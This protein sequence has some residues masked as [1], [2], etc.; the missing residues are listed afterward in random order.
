MKDYSQ[1][2]FYHFN[3]D[4]IILVN[5]VIK[6]L[7]SINSLLDI[8]AGCGVLGIEIARTIV[9]NRLT[10]LEAQ[11]DFIP[12]LRENVGYFIPHINVSIVNK[13]IHEMD[14]SLFDVIVC[15]PPYYL[16]GHG[17]PSKDEKRNIAR[18]FILDSWEILLHKIK[19]NL[20]PDGVAFVLIPELKSVINLID[21]QI[22]KL[23]FKFRIV[24]QKNFLIYELKL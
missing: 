18:T 16:P 6:R 4:S 2:D 8:G 12:F 20:S 1:P 11:P 17:I 23:D 5:E 3:Q 19:S 14:D 21:G 24:N 9:V 13:R 22:K 7:K 15:N 10:L